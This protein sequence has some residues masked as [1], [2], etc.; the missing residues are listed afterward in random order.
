[1]FHVLY[2]T[3]L[4][5]YS[6]LGDQAYITEYEVVETRKLKELKVASFLESGGTRLDVAFE[7]FLRKVFGKVINRNLVRLAI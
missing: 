4:S 7:N 1:M 3:H 2:V 5:L 6:R